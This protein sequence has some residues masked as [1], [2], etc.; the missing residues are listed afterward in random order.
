MPT[1][2]NSNLSAAKIAKN[3]EFYTRWE[4][5]QCE[6]N[7]YLE[8]NPDVFR[9]K[10]ILLPCDDPEWS[11]FTK[12]FALHFMDFGLKKLIS[13]SYAPNSNAGGVF[14][15]QTLFEIENPAYDPSKSMEKGR[16]FTL[17][18]EDL[19]GDGVININD[20]TW[21][22][23]EGDGDFRSPEIVALRDEADLI[24][25]NGPF[26]LFKEFLQWIIDGGKGFAIIGNKNAITY[27]EVFPRIKD[28]QMWLGSTPHSV[29]LLFRMPKIL[30]EELVANS[31]AGSGYRIIGGEVFG[32]AS[33]VWFTNIEHGRRHEPLSLMTLQENLNFSKHRKVKENGYLKYENYDAIE[34]PYTDAIPS[35]CKGIMGVPISFLDKYNPDQFEIVGMCENEDLYQLK[36]KRYSTEECKQAYLDKFGKKGVYDLN[37]SG[38]VFRNDRLEKVYQRI[39]I[40]HKGS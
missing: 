6:M 7:A 13:T 35:D 26:S 23:L 30:E 11:N 36:S 15:E 17:A 32:R 10:V 5:I 2:K 14:Y 3:D 38:V 27:S 16:V 4:D 20:L 22:Y 19:T 12:F 8:Y 39:L 25:T 1:S 29:D 21:K 9:D 28:N 31:K 37:A 40:R 33:A 24:I 34:V 18:R